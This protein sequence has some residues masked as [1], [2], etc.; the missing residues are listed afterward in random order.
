MLPSLSGR[1][2]KPTHNMPGSRSSWSAL[3]G[4]SGSIENG[5]IWIWA[6]GRSSSGRVL[7]NPTMSNE[8][9]ASGPRRVVRYC[10][11]AACRPASVLSSLLYPRSSASRNC[12][13]NTRCSRS[14]APTF[15]LS[16]TTSTPADRSV[17]AG[18]MPESWRILG[19]AMVP[20]ARIT[21]RVA[22]SLDACRR[23][24]ARRPPG[25]R[26]EHHPVDDRVQRD[27]QVRAVHDRV[28]ERVGRADPAAVA[29]RRHRVADAFLV[30]LV[31][32]PH[33]AP[34]ELGAGGDHVLEQRVARR[35]RSRRAAGRPRRGRR[36]RRARGPRSA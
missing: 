6:S 24:L 22:R 20:V 26:L 1:S 10:N 27:G 31:E 23:A 21:S 30:G 36:R 35:R 15:G 19:V 2:M 32:V 9:V 11:A 14:R 25:R 5:A 16:T 8:G 18:P 7:K 33:P 28:Q 17:S 29:D 12:S 34:T 13:M 4:S 3:P